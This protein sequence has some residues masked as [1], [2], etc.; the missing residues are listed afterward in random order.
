[1]TPPPAAA[2]AA[3]AGADAAVDMSHFM[4]AHVQPINSVHRFLLNPVGPQLCIMNAVGWE[5]EGDE[6]RPTYKP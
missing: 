1:M 4:T 2:A 6:G 3:A 5:L